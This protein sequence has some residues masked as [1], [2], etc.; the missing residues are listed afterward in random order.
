MPVEM[1]RRDRRRA[2]FAPRRANRI[3]HALARTIS[4]LND[5]SWPLWI[6]ICDCTAECSANTSNETRRNSGNE[7]TRNSISALVHKSR[8]TAR[9]S[10]RRSDK[11]NT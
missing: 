10:S 7:S 3:V 4:M 9:A 2:F 1:L 6:P 11:Y 5:L 8:K